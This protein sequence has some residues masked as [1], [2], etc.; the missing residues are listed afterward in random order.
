MRGKAKPD[1][2]PAVEW[3]DPTDSKQYIAQVDTGG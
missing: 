2:R 1:G 3:I